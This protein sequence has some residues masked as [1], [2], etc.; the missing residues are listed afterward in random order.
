MTMVR[1]QPVSLTVSR[2]RMAAAPLAPPPAPDPIFVGFTGLP[3]FVETVLFTGIFG[4]AAWAGIHTGLSKKAGSTLK[5]AGWAGGIGSALAGI[6]YLGAKSGLSEM[7]G[8]PA[9]RITPS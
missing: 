2:P 5:V 9:V 6:L 4:A 7:V 3:G 8:L 1:F